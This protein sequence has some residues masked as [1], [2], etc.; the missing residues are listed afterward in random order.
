MLLH[1][2]YDVCLALII[3]H[4]AYQWL[5]VS[6]GRPATRRTPAMHSGKQFPVR[7]PSNKTS[8][9]CYGAERISVEVFTPINGPL[10]LM[11][12]L[13]RTPLCPVARAQ[14]ISRTFAP[15]L[16]LHTSRHNK[17]S[18]RVSLGLGIDMQIFRSISRKKFGKKIPPG[19]PDP[20]IF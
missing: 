10:Y 5:A 2:A 1:V 17:I 9:P 16:G 11:A 13:S 12:V 6:M 7:V 19:G 14:T 20:Q 4:C 3:D 18:P 15:H 8:L